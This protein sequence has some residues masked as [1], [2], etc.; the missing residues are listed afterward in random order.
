MVRGGAT[1]PARRLLVVRSPRGSVQT[2]LL[3]CF[4]QP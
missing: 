1:P 2:Q 3:E 4:V